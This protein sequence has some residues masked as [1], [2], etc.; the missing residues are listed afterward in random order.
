MSEWAGG[1]DGPAERDWAKKAKGRSRGEP[2]STMQ[3]NAEKEEEDAE[4]N[5]R[6]MS[7][8][9]MCQPALNKQTGTVFPGRN[10]G[11]LCCMIT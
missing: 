11:R 5:A 2:Y 10:S 8:N 1:R 3:C 7:L 6:T 4:M 9:A